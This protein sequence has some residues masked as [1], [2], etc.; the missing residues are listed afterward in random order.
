MTD[1]V[2]EDG[3]RATTLVCVSLYPADV[4]LKPG[5]AR[6]VRCVAELYVTFCAALVVTSEWSC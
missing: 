4:T 1:V 3:V 5:S 2:Y 6:A